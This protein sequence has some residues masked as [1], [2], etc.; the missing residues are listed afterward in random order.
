M[1][2]V[3]FFLQDGRYTD[4]TIATEEGSFK[5]HQI[6]LSACSPYFQTLIDSSPCQNPVIFLNGIKA[7]IFTQLLNYMY[8]G[9]VQVESG[10]LKDVLEHANYLQIRSVLTIKL[11]LLLYFSIC[12]KLSV[13]ILKYIIAKMFTNGSCNL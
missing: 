5:C 12:F 6:V 7:A 11:E 1:Y 4:V 10:D 8:V 3:H 2:F 9:Q 13:S